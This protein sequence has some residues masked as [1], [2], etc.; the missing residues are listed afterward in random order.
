M[1]LSII[2]FLSQWF[3]TGN[4]SAPTGN[5]QQDV[6]TFWLSQMGENDTGIWWVKAKHSLMLRAAPYKNYLA[7]N[8]SKCQG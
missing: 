6:K 1:Y 4:E 8:I 2:Y 5:I 7:Q 3:S